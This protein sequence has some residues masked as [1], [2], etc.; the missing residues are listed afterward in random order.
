MKEA[1]E[2][3]TSRLT[4][5]LNNQ[6]EDTAHDDIV[7][8]IDY[9]QYLT[10][11]N[12]TGADIDVDRATPT[13]VRVHTEELAAAATPTPLTTNR[14][15]TKSASRMIRDDLLQQQ[16]ELA[17]RQTDLK[18][19][20][21]K[22]EEEKLQEIKEYHQQILKYKEKKANTMELTRINKL[23]MHAEKLDI[24]IKLLKI[25]QIELKMLNKTKENRRKCSGSDS[26]T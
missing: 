1:A 22:V 19:K 8:E 26:S 13:T 21:L 9:S 20:M 10:P 24:K 6:L 15:N 23:K 5:G 2:G 16:I 3:S 17:Q 12:I 4:F 25:K 11:E 14:Q 18:E 7:L